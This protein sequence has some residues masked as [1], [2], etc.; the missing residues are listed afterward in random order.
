MP[1]PTLQQKEGNWEL[2]WVFSKL[3][4]VFTNVVAVSVFRAQI[5]SSSAKKTEKKG[6]FLSPDCCRLP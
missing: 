4:F 6:D 1:F 5:Y 3:R 2:P